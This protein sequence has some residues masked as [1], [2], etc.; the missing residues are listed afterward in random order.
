[1][2]YWGALQKIVTIE[3]VSLKDKQVA[4]AMENS[5]HSYVSKKFECMNKKPALPSACKDLA[6]FYQAKE[7]YKNTIKQHPNWLDNS[8]HW[9]TPKDHHLELNNFNIAFK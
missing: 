8:L 3:L 7:V 6:E 5:F 1:M 2:T 4:S 9:N